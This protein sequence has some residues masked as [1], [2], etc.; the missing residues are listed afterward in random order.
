[1]S[2]RLTDLF[3]QISAPVPGWREDFFTNMR[4]ERLRYGHAPAIDPDNSRGTIV[5]THG[6]GEHIELYNHAIRFYQER[7]FNVWMMEWQGH[8]RSDRHDPVCDTC[9][10]GTDGP[11]G[12]LS[13][14]KDLE[15]FTNDIVQKEPGKPV[16]MSTN[17]MGGHIGLLALKYNPDMFDGAIMST[18]MF[19]IYRL[20]LPAFMRP[21]VQW[22]FNM[23][24]KTPL[25]DFQLPGD[26]K[27]L[28]ALTGVGNNLK[29]SPQGEM[30]I[31]RE[32]NQ[33]TRRK[34]AD[35][36]IDR[37]TPEWVAAAYNTI[38][39][40]LK[41]SFLRAVKTPMLVGSAGKDNL[42]DNAAIA[43]VAQHTAQT[44]VVS[45]PS[46]EHSL[47]FENDGNYNSWTGR[48]D[49]FL[50]RLAPA[51]VQQPPAPAE[52]GPLIAQNR[53]QLPLAA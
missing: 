37:P 47:W 50:D 43:Q 21:A 35:I 23:L 4:G 5:M 26:V 19:D 15:R 39:P 24:A 2:K 30:D 8:G 52:N 7:G 44:E 25:A 27:L 41:D 20:G 45:L 10:D 22:M 38:V 12:M 14:M 33:A 1:M 46:A 42:V 40:S 18:P 3:N 48:I 11:R 53:P 51:R 13:H 17:S 49:A 9:E 34:Y 36:Q 6:Y 31:R 28:N 32:W 29:D 16:I